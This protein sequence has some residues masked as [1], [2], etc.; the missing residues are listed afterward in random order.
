MK[1]Y[2]L[3]K[4]KKGKLQ[5]WKDWCGLLMT[6]R[7]KEAE[8]SLSKENVLSEECLY[9]TY[10]D[11]DFVLGVV[12]YD[13]ELLPADMDLEVN[14]EHKKQKQ[15]CLEYVTTLESLYEFDS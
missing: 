14:R 12:G 15:E 5:Q 4:V 6:E 7:R 10:N 1:K 9:F 8:E 3:L 11:E 13:T 2:T